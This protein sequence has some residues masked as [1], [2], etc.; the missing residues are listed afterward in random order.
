MF[1]S[2]DMETD[3]EVANI[4][5]PSSQQIGI[6]ATADL[7]FRSWYEA[8]NEYTGPGMALAVMSD[9]STCS[10]G[11]AGMRDTSS[12]PRVAWD[13]NQTYSYAAFT[14]GYY[15]SMYSI[16]ADANALIL[17]LGNNVY[18]DDDKVES[19]A[20]FGQ[21]A[22]LGSL[23]LVFDRVY[24]SDETGTLNNGEPYNYDDAMEIALEKLDL[25][26][27]AA[28]RGDFTLDTQINGTTLTSAQWS[29]FLNSYG[30]R[31]LANSARNSTQRAALDWDKVLDY[32]NNGLTY[33]L[34]VTGQGFGVW[35]SLWNV[36]AIFGGWTRIDLYTINLMDNDY[37]D[38]WPTGATTLDEAESDDLRLTSDFEYL[39]SQNFIASRG[40]YHYSS[41]RYSRYDAYTD[42]NWSTSHPEYLSAENDLY[43][44]EALYRTGDL[45]G[46]AAVINA[47]T[48]TTRGGLP[49][50]S[51]TESEIVDA[52]HYERFVELPHTGMGLPF[53]EMRGKDLLQSGTFLHF[54]IPGAAINAAGLEYYTFGGTTGVAGED[55]STGGW[56]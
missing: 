37:P 54:P 20:R 42:S 26:I 48:R 19:L 14:E 27:A 2:C 46:A 32:A 41:Y 50:I 52:L 3:L 15:N 17:P 44:A 7:L 47:G 30:A 23:A 29:E 31:L 36:Y 4:E 56:R 45:A 53:F 12:E 10:W 21:A 33:D 38:Y 22:A 16:L 28:D 11:N 5:Q 8:V 40:E 55:Y 13:N 35:T 25:A 9:N 43:K 51:A 18:S 49:E 34:E 39:S 24:A 6:E 1:F